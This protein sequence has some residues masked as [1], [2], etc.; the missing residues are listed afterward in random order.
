MRKSTKTNVLPV[1]DIVDLYTCTVHLHV[2]V[3]LV[4]VHDRRSTRPGN[5]ATGVKLG[6]ELSRA[7]RPIE[8]STI[9]AFDW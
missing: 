7:A 9:S 1:L 6:L 4:P 3:L 2:W 8:M 5:E